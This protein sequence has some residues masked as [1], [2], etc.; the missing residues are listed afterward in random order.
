[1]TIELSNYLIDKAHV[2]PRFSTVRRTIPEFVSDG[3]LILDTRLQTDE[4]THEQGDKPDSI[5]IRLDD[6]YRRGQE[7]AG[8]TA[9]PQPAE[10]LNAQ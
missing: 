10:E 6:A 7:D 8:T 4:P 3:V 5:S 2:G 1:M 9:S